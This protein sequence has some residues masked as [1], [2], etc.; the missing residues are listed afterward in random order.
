MSEL[1][2]PAAAATA[3]ADPATTAIDLSTI[4]QHHPQLRAQVAMHPAAYPGLLDW[5]DGL[6][7]PMLSAVVAVR[8][9][10]DRA[11]QA[12][13]SPAAAPGP[14]PFAPDGPTFAPVGQA[15]PTAAWVES[16]QPS[17]DQPPA[18]APR[19]RKRLLVAAAAVVVVFALVAGF[20]TGGFGLLRRGGAATPQEEATKIADKSVR[21]FNSFSLKNLIDNPLAAIG[22]LSDEIAPSESSLESKFTKVDGGDLFALSSDSL[23]LASD[24]L[25][26]FN[27][28]A[29]GLKTSVTEFTD[30][31]AAVDFTDGEV[32]V[33]ADVDRLKQ[34]LKKFP[35]VAAAQIEATLGRY[36]LK[37]TKP[38]NLDLPS[39]WSDEFIAAVDDQFPYRVD[40]ADCAKWRKTGEVP[41]KPELGTVCAMIS[42]IMVVKD[43]G[44]WYLSPMLTWNTDGMSTFVGF[45]GQNKLA[46]PDRQKMLSVEA[47]THKEPIDAPTGVLSALSTDDEAAKLAEFPLAE[48]RYAAATSILTGAN[49]SGAET[50]SHFS[51][52]A[53]SGN[54]AKVRIDQLKIGSGSEAFEIKDGTC[55]SFAS[56]SGCLSDL[57]DSAALED[58]FAGLKSQDWTSFEQSTGI[59]GDKVISKL[60]TASKAALKSIDP[61]QVGLIAVQENGTWLFSFTASYSELQNQLA[62][63]IRAGL[64]S[65]QE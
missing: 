59:S 35:D 48:R 27:V 43:A 5:L 50:S 18:S 22:D 21:L 39:G 47:T 57:Q 24:F 45:G 30:E 54:Q 20:M 25:G 61:Q 49:L 40:L 60:E 34:A 36:G 33:I 16:S 28:K 52:I 13:A 6:G 46:S 23:S 8:R 44:S 53:R 56:T 14:V 42:R 58:V 41:D 11:H 55:I 32:T 12:A 63:A 1:T 9:D 4:A 65:I 51:E 62:A 26:A 3:L 15:Q 64:L 31:V 10:A 17:T 19:G 29:D 2:D 7:D 38:V 37:P